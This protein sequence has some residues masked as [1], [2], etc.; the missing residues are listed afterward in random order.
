MSFRERRVFEKTREF[1]VSSAQLAR[2]F[3]KYVSSYEMCVL[4]VLFQIT[5]EKRALFGS[6]V[7]EKMELSNKLQYVKYLLE[8]WPFLTHKIVKNIAVSEVVAST[9]TVFMKQ[10]AASSIIKKAYG[11][12]WQNASIPEENTQ[13]TSP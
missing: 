10:V 5:A 11:M 12:D 2:F 7:F 9:S 4:I 6:G 1:R 13:D 8:L 3:S